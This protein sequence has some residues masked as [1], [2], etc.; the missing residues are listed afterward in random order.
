MPA[1]DV[2]TNP[3]TLDG[4]RGKQQTIVVTATNRLGR[5]VM[6][7]AVAVVNPPAAAGWVT[8]PPDAQRVFTKPDSTEKFTFGF[9]VDPAAPA[10]NYT[11]R[12]DVM[13]VDNPDDNFGKS[14]VIAVQVP[15]LVVQPPP[16]PPPFKWWILVAAAVVVLGI[17][18]AVW[19]IFFSAK[20]MPDV[21]KKPYSE[22]IAALPFDSARWVITRRDTAADT[23]DYAR[24]VVISQDIAAKTKLKGDTPFK[25]TLVVQQDFA[26]VPDLNGLDDLT[27][28]ERL[29]KEGLRFA[30][31]FDYKPTT[32]PEEGK[33]VST[34]PVKGTIV[35]RNTQ[36]TF[37]I[38]ATS[39]PCNDPRCRI[40]AETVLNEKWKA[41]LPKVIIPRGQ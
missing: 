35:P 8:P 13:D 9:L 21:V 38:R 15:E 39:Q 41:T 32:T 19:K 14:A 11:V 31:S 20:K 12:I 29:A 40:R 27:A 18:F 28:V 23:T 16:P 33:V 1:F 2:T 26:V 10:G 3:T 37:A 5:Q 22:A 25:L 6:A 17:G 36:V 30:R 34:H 24:Q 7:R 4:T